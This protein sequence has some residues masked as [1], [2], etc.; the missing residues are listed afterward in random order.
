MNVVFCEFESHRTPVLFF[1][2]GYGGFGRFIKFILYSFAG[3]H[4]TEETKRKIGSANAVANKGKV[5][6]FCWIKKDNEKS[7]RIRKSEIQSWLTNGWTKGR[8]MK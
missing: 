5:T 7:I 3:K 8:K 4:H 6:D 1:L 2:R